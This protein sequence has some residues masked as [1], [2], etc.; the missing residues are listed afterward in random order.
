MHEVIHAQLFAIGQAFAFFDNEIAVSPE[1]GAAENVPLTGHNQLFA[2]IYELKH[3]GRYAIG[4]GSQINNA[5][6]HAAPVRFR[7][8]GAGL[9]PVHD[10]N[11]FDAPIPD[12]A[13]QHRVADNSQHGR[14]VADGDTP[15]IL[16][17]LLR[18]GGILMLGDHVS[19]HGQQSGSRFFLFRWAV[20]GVGPDHAHLS[21]RVSFTYAQGEGVDTAHNFGNGEGSHVTDD[22]AL[23]GRTGYQTR[24]VARLIHPAEDGG[25]IVGRLVAGYMD[26]PG[27]GELL[28]YRDSGIHVAKRGGDD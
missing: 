13:G 28:S 3:I 26:K 21:I 20:P 22:V 17:R 5:I 7:S 14:V 23:G 27:V 9:Y 10:V 1:N 8:I 16:G 18:F 12:R 2:G 24:Q 19:A 4:I 25:D 11:V 6:G 15:H